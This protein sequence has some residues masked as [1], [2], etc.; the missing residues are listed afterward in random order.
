MK[1]VRAII[2][3]LCMLYYVLLT[4]VA[5]LVRSLFKGIDFQYSIRRR[6]Q[7]VH[8]IFP[9]LGIRMH[10]S[11]IPPDF[12]CLLMANHRSYLDPALLAHDALFFGVAKAEVAKWPM[13]GYA[14]KV[15]GAVF[16]QRE[17]KTSRAY[18]LQSIAEKLKT[19]FSV[20]LF[21]EGTTH[22]APATSDFRMG[23]FKVAIEAQVPVVPVALEYRNKA[24]YWIGDDSF[25]SH[26][27]HRFG[28][29]VMDVYVRYGDPLRGDDPLEL[30][31]RTKKWIDTELSNIQKS[32]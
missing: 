3:L 8:R 20:L 13:L 9:L 19:G 2:R 29:P 16:I 5:V 7:F 1:K 11:G 18:S 27:F 23:G 14:I 12:P 10:V 6:Q 26:F 4:I 24:D 25:V 17:S 31:D 30:L 21:P 28:E 32:F 15:T 22:D